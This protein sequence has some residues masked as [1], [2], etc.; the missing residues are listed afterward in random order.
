VTTPPEGEL[1]E[2][3]EGVDPLD[4]TGERYEAPAGLDRWEAYAHRVRVGLLSTCGVALGLL[5]VVQVW[6]GFKLDPDRYQVV[7]G[8]LN[9]ANSLLAAVIGAAGLYYFTRRN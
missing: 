5:I 2:Y 7:V 6:M 4:L 8:P 1:F 9:G 3:S